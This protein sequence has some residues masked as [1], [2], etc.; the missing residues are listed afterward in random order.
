M[1]QPST[2][3]VGAGGFLGGAVHRS[4]VGS[5]AATIAARV[6]WDDQD[7]A[8]EALVDAF[9]SVRSQP[10]RWRVLWCAGTGVVATGADVFD[11]EQ[12]LIARVLDATRD[13]P[14]GDGT[15]FFASS[16][17]AVY[18]GSAEPP[19]DEGT[20]PL[21]LAP[22]GHAK[23]AAEA[24]FR[25]WAAET[26]TRLVVGRISNLYGPGANLGKP[27][28]LVSQLT[29]AHLEGRPSSI[30]VPMST[31]RD[32]LYIDDAVDMVLRTI[33]L[34]EQAPPAAAVTKILA[35]GQPA[36][37]AEV[38]DAVEQAIG[39]RLDIREGADPSATFQGLDLRMRSEVLPQVGDR[40]FVP[41]PQG[42]ATTVEAIRARRAPVG[43]EPAEQ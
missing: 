5:D 12:R 22:Y 43:A 39:S 17:G 10:G 31:T 13:D 24:Q 6:P 37:I 38:I 8:V 2:L 15:L 29:L 36:T 25:S 7:A 19:F 4:L 28:G 42:V 14:S 32:Y 35:S 9:R 30:Y 33:D 3:V 16:A 27:Q 18:A 40:T 11:E 41:F 20:E 1:T 26:G 34:V 21:P 23:L